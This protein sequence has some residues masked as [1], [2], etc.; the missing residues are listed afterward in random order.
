M[1]DLKITNLAP[2]VLFVYNRLNHTIK[3]VEALKKNTLAKESDLI[4]YSDYPKNTN[5]KQS[6]DEVR[7]FIKYV[8]GFK[9][10]EIVYRKVNFGVDRSIVD[11]VSDVIEKYRRVIVLE[12]DLITSADFIDYMNR[13]LEHY[14]NNERV[15]SITGVSYP[16]DIP[17]SYTED[18]Y[19]GCRCASWSWA[20]WYNRWE[21][22]D[23]EIN[24]TV[25]REFITNK[26]SVSRFNLGGDDMSDTLTA[27]V[28]G[29]IMTWDIL[30]CFAHF[31]NNAY[32]L[33]PIESKISNIGLDGSGEHCTKKSLKFYTGASNNSIIFPKKIN[34]NDQIV[35]NLKKLHE[36]SFLSRIKKVIKNIVRY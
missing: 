13:A 26:D 18:V 35:S 31:R 19:L 1:S 17:D 32:C 22:F 14:F 27:R 6:V 8:D 3:T 10:V 7:E 15:F 36:Y 34:V 9:S 12:D 11:G 28:K 24:D 2:I 4:I 21:K 33:Y 30:W 5:S 20:T 25:Y 29:R 23:P 16:I